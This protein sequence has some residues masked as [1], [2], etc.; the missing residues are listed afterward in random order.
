MEQDAPKIEP[1][2]GR[3]I[4]DKARRTI[5]SERPSIP[6]NDPHDLRALLATMKSAKVQGVHMAIWDRDIKAVEDAIAVIVAI[7]GFR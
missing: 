5:V 3:L 1:G 2:R 6:I 7:R 4:Y